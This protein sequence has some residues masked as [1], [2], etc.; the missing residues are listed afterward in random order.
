MTILEE[1]QAQIAELTAKA[2]QIRIE[3]RSE[4]VSDAQAIITAYH[5]KASDFAF[6][7]SA[8]AQV[9]SVKS[10]APKATKKAEIKFRDEN[11]NS[12][13]GRGLKPRWLASALEGGKTLADFSVQSA[14]T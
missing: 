14:Q 6:S 8:S 4:A 7:K 5:L 9:E 10:A 3:K 1:I 11:G 12:W 13:S 2:N